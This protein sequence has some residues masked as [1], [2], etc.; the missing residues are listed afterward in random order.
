MFIITSHFCY[1]RRYRRTG[2]VLEVIYSLKDAADRNSTTTNN[3]RSVLDD[4][5]DTGNDSYKVVQ[6]F[7]EDNTV[8]ELSKSNNT[9]SA[10]NNGDVAVENIELLNYRRLN[11]GNSQHL[12]N[13]Q[14]RDNNHNNVKKDVNGKVPEEKKDI[15][16]SGTNNNGLCE[17]TWDGITINNYHDDNTSHEDN[18]NQELEVEDDRGVQCVMTDDEEKDKEVKKSSKRL[19]DDN[20]GT[21]GSNDESCKKDEELLT[22]IVGNAGPNVVELGVSNEAFE[23]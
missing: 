14:E 18:T 19:V 16:V 9:G 12:V 1:L 21:T 10:V 2:T 7:Q 17:D 5:V 8:D 13:Q 22:T 11:S 23:V 15:A 4:I 6:L 20:N 3:R